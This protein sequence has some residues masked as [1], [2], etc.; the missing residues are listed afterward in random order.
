MKLS[1][2]HLVSETIIFELRFAASVL[3]RSFKRSWGTWSE[4]HTRSLTTIL[5]TVSAAQPS[6]LRTP[7]RGLSVFGVDILG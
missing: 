5:P 1:I 4:G 7:F 6:Y 3:H 2:W